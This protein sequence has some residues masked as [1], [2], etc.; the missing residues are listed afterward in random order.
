M[1]TRTIRPREK[2]GRSKEKSDRAKAGPGRRPAAKTSISSTG[3]PASGR[4]RAPA[5]A[6]TGSATARNGPATARKPARN[7]GPALGGHGRDLA[8]LAVVTVALLSALAI[9]GGLAGPVGRTL[10]DGTSTGFGLARYG[11]P[12]VLAAGGAWVLRRRP[13]QSPARL[14]FGLAL[15]TVA[16][17][18]LLYL[19]R[20][21]PG[22]DASLAQVRGAGGV[23]GQAVGEPLRWA[24]ASWGAAAVLIAALGVGFL[25]L[26]STTV[27]D[28]AGHASSWARSVGRALASAGRAVADVAATLVPA[29]RP[30]DPEDDGARAAPR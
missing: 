20:G 16:A 26:G 11:L 3:K 5:K 10:S 7:R 24:L 18:G 8:G 15:V 12:V 21:G 30:A 17:C 2:A 25:V 14:A 28:S 4:K 9:Y 22:F 27:K 1:A 13:G 29:P 19:A 23:V 6:R